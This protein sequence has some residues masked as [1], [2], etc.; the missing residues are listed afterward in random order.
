M[1][2]I[3]GFVLILASSTILGFAYAEKFKK[4]VKELKEIQRG[5]YILKSEI[6][7][8]RSLLP[9]ALLKVSEKCEEPVSGIFSE[10]SHGLIQC[11]DMDV[12]TCFVNALKNNREKLNLKKDDESILT[13]LAKTLGSTDI[14]G[15]ND[16]FILT[17]ENLGRAIEDAED[18]EN[19]NVKMYRYLGF[20]LGMMIAIILL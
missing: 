13:D 8:T 1:I 7:Y 16:I 12:Y 14:E 3:I 4:R 19:K 2:K 6:N 5:V 9:E 15:H 17:L 11:D 18:K 20:S 10:V